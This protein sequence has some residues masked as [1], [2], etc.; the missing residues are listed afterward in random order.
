MA[1][2]H[3]VIGTTSDSEGNVHNVLKANYATTSKRPTG[4]EWFECPVN[5]EW[6]PKSEG[7]YYRGRWLSP[8]AA[9]DEMHED[10][11]RNR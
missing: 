10:K 8:E 4:E 7:V 6:L 3:E 5:L 1:Q 11:R 9:E 2:Q